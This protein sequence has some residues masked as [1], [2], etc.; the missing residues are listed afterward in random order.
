MLLNLYCSF[1]FDI[2]ID[3]DIISTIKYC[4]TCI[5]TQLIYW[6]KYKI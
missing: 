2:N 3:I 4:K 6:I 5:V 1:I